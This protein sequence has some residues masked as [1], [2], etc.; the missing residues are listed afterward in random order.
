MYTSASSDK[1]AAE[2]F[3]P[4]CPRCEEQVGQQKCPSL[5]HLSHLSQVSHLFPI[6]EK[7]IERRERERRAAA[8]RGIN[9]PIRRFAGTGETNAAAAGISAGTASGTEVRQVR[10]LRE[11]TRQAAH[12]FHLRCTIA[13]SHPI[14]I[15][16]LHHGTVVLADRQL[17]RSPPWRSPTATPAPRPSYPS[18]T[19]ATS[20]YD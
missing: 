16:P 7:K 6:K 20:F 8:A 11:A 5:L 10:R 2:P 18:R 4:T 13:P 14:T 1:S 3:C 12:R 17:R 9:G 15:T 19:A